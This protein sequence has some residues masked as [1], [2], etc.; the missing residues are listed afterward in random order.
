M[1]NLQDFLDDPE[2]AKYQR[3]VLKQQNNIRKI[4]NDIEKE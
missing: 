4:L 3:A 2:G 1:Y